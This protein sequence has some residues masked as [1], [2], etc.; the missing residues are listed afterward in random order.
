MKSWPVCSSKVVDKK[1]SENSNADALSR[2][3]NL[4]ELELEEERDQAEFIGAVETELT[5]AKILEAQALDETLKLGRKWLC[6]GQVKYDLMGQSLEVHKYRQ[7]VGAL[8]VSEDG[9]FVFE[10]EGSIVGG[11]KQLVLVPDALKPVFFYYC[12]QHLSAGHYGL[13]AIRA[14]LVRKKQP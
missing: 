13:T 11:K 2:S 5:R 6:S 1:G 10:A 12:H 9:V 8:K 3:D 14:L 7:L 4:P